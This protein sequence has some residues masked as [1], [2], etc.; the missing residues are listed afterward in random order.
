MMERCRF[1]FC[2]LVQ[3]V[4]SVVSRKYRET[5]SSQKERA[6]ECAIVLYSCNL[7]TR[8][9]SFS[10]IANC[11]DIWRFIAAVIVLVAEVFSSRDCLRLRSL[12]SKRRSMTVI[13]SLM[14]MAAIV[15]IFCL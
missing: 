14:F 10:E 1:H 5:G 2:D 3:C 13:S 4:V 12:T 8:T 15:V 9:V 11:A 7:Q 6:S